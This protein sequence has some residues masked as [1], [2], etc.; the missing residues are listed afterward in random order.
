MKVVGV[1]VGPYLALVIS[2]D[3]MANSSEAAR[4]MLGGETNL[5]V[6]IASGLV[7]PVQLIT[8]V[9]LVLVCWAE[10]RFRGPRSWLIPLIF[11][12]IA[13]CWNI[14]LIVQRDWAELA[15]LGVL[16]IMAIAAGSKVLIAVGLFFGI[17]WIYRPKPLTTAV[18]SD[19]S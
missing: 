16:Q 5:F 15:S 7:K 4:M 17:A 9:L 1:W 11:L 8:L 10:I 19:R 14:L 3:R 18:D 2:Y 6:K 13:L 12:P